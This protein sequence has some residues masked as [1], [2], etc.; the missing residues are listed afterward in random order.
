MEQPH[1]VNVARETMVRNRTICQAATSNVGSHGYMHLHE[2]SWMQSSWSHFQTSGKNC[3][4]K[5]MSETGT[6]PL[7]LIR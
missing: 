2:L 7:A 6:S 1:L 3:S 5:L 4:D